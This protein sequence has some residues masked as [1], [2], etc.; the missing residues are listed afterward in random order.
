[1]KIIIVPNMLSRPEIPD[2][3]R[4]RTANIIIHEHG[5]YEV[6]NDNFVNEIIYIKTNFPVDNLISFLSNI[7]LKKTIFHLMNKYRVDQCNIWHIS[8]TFI[9]KKTELIKLQY[10][11][12]I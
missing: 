5:S 3:V 7:K 2:I 1:M 10:L 8:E 6:I 11:D 9:L 4:N 12:F